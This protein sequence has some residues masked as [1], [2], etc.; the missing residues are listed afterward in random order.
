[1]PGVSVTV[2]REFQSLRNFRSI[3]VDRVFR[4]FLLLFECFPLTP[5]TIKNLDK[6]RTYFKHICLKMR[7]ILAAL[8]SYDMAILFEGRTALIGFLSV[9]I[10]T[11]YHD[12]NCATISAAI[13]MIGNMLH[14]H[15]WKRLKGWNGL[16]QCRF[17][18]I[19]CNRRF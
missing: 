14:Y 19:F 5:Q 8:E 1:M 13:V 11:T 16:Q 10:M 6:G 9:R 15:N 17:K 18:L 12:S 3:F 4:Q 2:L 7:K